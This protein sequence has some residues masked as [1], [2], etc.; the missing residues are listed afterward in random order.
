MQIL[1]T[2]KP[3]GN[4]YI[5]S[6]MNAYKAAGHSVFGDVSNFFHSNIVPDVLH[7]HWPERLHEW[8]P[9]KGTLAD[10]W[11]TVIESRLKWYKDNNVTIVHTVHNLGPHEAHETASKDAFSLVID[12]ADIIVHHCANSISLVNDVFPASRNKKNI[13]CPHGDYLINYRP[14]DRLEAR[15]RLGLPE[16]RIIVLNFGRQRPYKNERFVLSAFSKVTFPTKYLLIAGDFLYPAPGTWRRLML[17]LRNHIRGVVPRKTIKFIYKNFSDAGLADIVSA[18]DI[19]FLGQQRALNSGVLALAATFSRPVVF[20]EIGCFGEAM[21]GWW[22]ESF[23]AGNAAAAAGKLDRM[24]QEVAN[25]GPGNRPGNAA[26]LERN[27][28]KSHAD[29]ILRSIGR[30]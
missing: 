1:L 14:V 18:A 26:W 8:Y 4:A 29:N 6:L 17:R 12:Y 16:D 5:E 25:D 21:G 20:P 22:G 13:V 3:S 19:L 10:N 2:E 9:H 30:G 28:W 11:V 23:E 24:C 7:I 15:R 27:S